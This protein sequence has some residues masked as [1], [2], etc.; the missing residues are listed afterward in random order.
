[1]K[2]TVT[3]LFAGL[4]IAISAQAGDDY[5][6]KGGKEVIPPAP[7]PC[8]WTWF[9]G[10]S[11]GEVSGDWDEEIYTLH[12]G[13]ER[14]CPE[15]DC[16]H[17]FFLE[18]GYTEK[19]WHVDYMNPNTAS[20]IS[21][22]QHDVDLEIIPITLNYKYECSLTGSLNWYIGAG[23]G[24]ALCE[25]DISGDLVNDSDDDTTFYA[26]IFAGLTYNVSE[27]FEIFGG[28]RMIFMDDLFGLD[29]ALDEEAHYEIGAR[30]NF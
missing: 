23:A 10:G 25:Y 27:T 6:A 4:A 21:Y 3:T 15:S 29:S 28:V 2:K 20:N 13:V 26:H 17:S 14:K 9:A 7:A 5:S 19:D 16:T 18:V 8:L 24:I 1:M 11:A 12:V 22:L 30:I